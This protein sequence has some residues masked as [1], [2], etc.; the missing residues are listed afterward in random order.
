MRG[1]SLSVEEFP[2]FPKLLFSHLIFFFLFFLPAALRAERVS[3]ALSLFFFF[4][5][6]MIIT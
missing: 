1:C 3:D 5:R 6:I 4:V 2:S